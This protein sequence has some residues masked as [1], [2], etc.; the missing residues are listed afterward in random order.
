MKGKTFAVIIIEPMLEYRTGDAEEQV[1][2]SKK[3]M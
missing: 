3:L 2:N 1:N